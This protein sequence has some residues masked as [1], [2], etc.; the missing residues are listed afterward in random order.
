MPWA[1]ISPGNRLLARRRMAC[2]RLAAAAVR[3]A[4]GVVSVGS[5][6]HEDTPGR[7]PDLYPPDY[8]PPDSPVP[9]AG[10]PLLCCLEFAILFI[11]S[12]PAGNPCLWVVLLLLLQTLATPGARRLTSTPPA[13]SPTPACRAT[14]L[15]CIHPVTPAQVACPAFPTA[16]AGAGLTCLPA[17]LLPAC[18]PACLHTPA[19]GPVAQTFSHQTPTLLASQSRRF[20]AVAPSCEQLCA[21]SWQQQGQRR[22]GQAAGSLPTCLLR[23]VLWWTSPACAQRSS[24]PSSPFACPCTMRRGGWA[25]SCFDPESPKAP[26]SLFFPAGER[27]GSAEATAPA[28]QLPLP[29]PLLIIKT[30]GG[31]P[32]MEARAVRRPACAAWGA[33][34]AL[35]VSAAA[36]TAGGAA[37]SLHTSAAAWQAGGGGRRGMSWGEAKQGKCG[38]LC[39][40]MGGY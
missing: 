13:M 18:L 14:I 4:R 21:S 28:G 40:A 39:R 9:G 16:V 29:L 19:H 8:S 26:L 2:C 5:P 12:I 33:S 3:P 7:H 6:G 31:N 22:A 34:R 23:L 20:L 17:C 35:H 36:R 15:T 24:P 10:W 38:G 1:L 27:L 32:F 37:S 30:D 25:A 11:P